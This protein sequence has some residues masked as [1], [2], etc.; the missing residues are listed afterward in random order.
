MSIKIIGLLLLLSA[1]IPALAETNQTLFCC[2]NPIRIFNESEIVN[3]TPLFQWW[4]QQA[5]GKPGTTAEAD[6]AE[7]NRPLSAWKRVMGVKVRQTEY[8]WVMNAEVAASPTTRTNE[9][10]LLQHPPTA[11][12]QR[13]DNL[14]P[15]P[16]EYNR[17][18]TNDEHTY[19]ADLKAEQAVEIRAK[20]DV[21]SWGWKTRLRANGY[22]QQAKEERAAADTALNDEKQTQQALERTQ[23]ELDA[24]PS[25]NG[26][27]QVDCFALETGRNSQGL[28]I[29]DPGEV[30][31]TNAP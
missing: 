18:I 14:K 26:Q 28:P 27:Y 15:L 21:R 3:L 31:S 25:V 8:A 4:K 7:A 10:I 11:E 17:Q 13:Y 12:E 23:K 6:Y 2:R 5:G 20:T 16:D 22:D 29:F 19:Q 24:I 30:A 9:R 1:A